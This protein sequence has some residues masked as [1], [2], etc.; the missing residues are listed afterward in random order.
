MRKQRGGSGL[1]VL[2]LVMVVGFLFIAVIG[3]AVDS[4]T[5]NKCLSLGY[6]ES[7]TTLTMQQYCIKRDYQGSM[8]SVPLNKAV[9]QQVTE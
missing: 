7:K 4:S 6:A 3:A 2:L 1:E 5:E 8:Y 9:K